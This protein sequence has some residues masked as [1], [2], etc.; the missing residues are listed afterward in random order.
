[1]KYLNIITAAL[2]MLFASSVFTACDD[3]YEIPVDTTIPEISVENASVINV[4]YEM[5][6][7][8]MAVKSNVVYFANVTLGSDW[9]SCQ[10]TDNLQTFTIKYAQNKTADQRTGTIELSKGD[11]SV[12]LTV[13]QEGDPN[14]AG[15]QDVDIPFEIGEAGGGMYKTVHI[16]TADAAKIPVG[17][18]IIFECTG[19][20]SINGDY[21]GFS[22][23]NLSVNNAPVS[24]V[25]TQEI[26]TAAAGEN[27][28]LCMLWDDALVTRIYIPAPTP[29]VDI[30]FTNGEA[31]GGMYKTVLISSADAANIPVGSTVIFEAT[32]EG[33]I[34]G[35]YTGFSMI[36]ATF[37]DGK[38]ELVWTEAIATASQGDNGFICM[39]FGDATVTRVYI[40]GTAT[41]TA[42][43]TRVNVSFTNGEAG[44]GMYKTVLISSA[45]AANIPVGSTVVFEA[46]GEGSVNGSYTGFSMVDATFANGR[47]ELVWTQAIATASQGDNGFICM[48]FGDATVTKV[49][50]TNPVAVAFS[51]GE[52]GGGMYKTVLIS[53]EEA[54]KIPVGSVV[55]FEATGAGSVNGSYTGFA[56]VDATFANGRATIT[57]TEAIA[58]A[59]QGDNGF[60]CM[61]F[62]DA[63]I[64][65]VN[66]Y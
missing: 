9:L 62:D 36:D 14:A 61:V 58:T 12:I 38:A 42:K 21:T 15:P 46:S 16:A 32:G 30:P 47:A 33:S 10:F 6:E 11:K 45:D 66:Y 44:G 31:G 65:A 64:T 34:N 1:M 51:N 50:Y 2:L 60:I 7:Q 37:A 22:M 4:G 52:A 8:V 13:V 35:A 48:I 26:A 27:G 17:K 39:I 19:V 43:P 5:G 56:M 54:A 63:V 57:W 29:D 23:V 40:P 18:T 28:F 20:G 53:K 41:P 55:V 59:S 3:G 49:Y 25:W 24:L